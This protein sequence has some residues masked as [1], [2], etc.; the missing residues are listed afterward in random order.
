MSYFCVFG[1][2]AYAH[3]PKDQWGKFD[4]KPKNLMFVGYNVVSSG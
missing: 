3:V 2:D 4:E 1:Y